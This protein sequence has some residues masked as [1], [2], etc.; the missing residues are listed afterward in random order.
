MQKLLSIIILLLMMFLVVQYYNPVRGSLMYLSGD[1]R[2]IVLT[3][4]SVLIVSLIL[5]LILMHISYSKNK[6]YLC[7]SIVSSI[8]SLWFFSLIKII[9]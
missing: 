2:G 3:S 8:F 7:I 4:V 1:R 6:R 9:E 5:S